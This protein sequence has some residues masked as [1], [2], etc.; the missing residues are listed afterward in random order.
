MT[1]HSR[2]E[3]MLRW[4]SIMI[5]VLGVAAGLCASLLI[6]KSERLQRS[7]SDMT[8]HDR[9]ASTASLGKERRRK[10]VP[11]DELTRLSHRLARVEQDLAQS[12]ERGAADSP[13][14]GAEQEIDEKEDF[15]RAEEKFLTAIREFESM[16]PDA[17]WAPQA[18]ASLTSELSA[19]SE[20]LGFEV[21]DVQCKSRQCVTQLDWPDARAAAAR[22]AEV[23]HARYSI[24]C[25]TDVVVRAS[26]DGAGRVRTPVVFSGCK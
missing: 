8:G 10:D 9:A 15:S 7:D 4:K 12:Q 13:G 11:P 19:L 17:D 23:V 18:S 5:A 25:M 16:P 14:D 22:V 3:T 24:N 26:H 6:E 1:G 21:A 2:E 20:G